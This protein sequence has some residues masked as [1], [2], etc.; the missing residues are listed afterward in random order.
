MVAVESV[1]A[2]TDDEED[3]YT[4]PALEAALVGVDTA[5]PP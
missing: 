3:F 4:Y 5:G 1:R 2:N